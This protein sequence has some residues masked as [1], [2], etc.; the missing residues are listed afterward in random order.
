MM[1]CNFCNGEVRWTNSW[2]RELPYNDTV[3][4]VEG[5]IGKCLECGEYDVVD[6]RFKNDR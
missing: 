4:Y 2:L 5:L 3:I 6:V 1:K